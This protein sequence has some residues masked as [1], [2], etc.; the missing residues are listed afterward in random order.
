MLLLDLVIRAI[1]VVSYERVANSDQ[2]EEVQSMNS[3]PSYVGFVSLARTRGKRQCN[4]EGRKASSNVSW[5][6]NDS[7]TMS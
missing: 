5:V 7:S 6:T 4:V 2:S 1:R 3:S